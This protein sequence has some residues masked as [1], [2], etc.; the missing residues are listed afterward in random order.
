M[1]SISPYIQLWEKIASDHLLN[2]FWIKK[3]IIIIFAA[4][5]SNKMAQYPAL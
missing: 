3:I 5:A 1:T 4:G 2:R